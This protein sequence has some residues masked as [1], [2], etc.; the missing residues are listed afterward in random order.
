MKTLF[1][2]PAWY[3]RRDARAQTVATVKLLRHK[4]TSTFSAEAP[5]ARPAVHGGPTND[6]VATTPQQA[7]APSAP[8]SPSSTPTPNPS[9]AATEVVA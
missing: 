7:E 8:S 3:A 2:T 4:N 1:F 6:A 5:Q 9:S